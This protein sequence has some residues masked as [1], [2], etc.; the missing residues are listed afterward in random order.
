VYLDF[1]FLVHRPRIFDLAYSLAFM[2]RALHGNSAPESFAWQ[3]IPR[4]IEAYET[5]A[6]SRLTAMEKKALVPYTASVPLHAA[7]LDGFT[8]NPAGQLQERLPF[9]RLSDWL[10]THPDSIQM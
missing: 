9:I 8:D 3:S 5:S 10:L 6:N 7:A 4:L 2:V 1:G